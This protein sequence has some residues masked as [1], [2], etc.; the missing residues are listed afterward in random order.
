MSKRLTVILDGRPVQVDAGTTV[1]A[2]LLNAGVT[3]FRHSVTGEPRAPLCGMG[4]CFECRV[5]VDGVEHC[6]SCQ[7]LCAEGM[8]VTTS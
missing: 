4:I 6:R 3:A 8:Q 1:A 2:A 7:T 5:T